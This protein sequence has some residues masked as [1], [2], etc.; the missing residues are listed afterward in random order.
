MSRT[1]PWPQ[2]AFASDTA[3]FVY[4]YCE[5]PTGGPLVVENGMGGNELMYPEVEL[6]DDS[7]AEEAGAEERGGMYGEDEVGGGEGGREGWWGLD[8]FAL[9]GWVVA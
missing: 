7:L 1:G 9:C 5:A 8:L 6:L 4:S 2:L 3:A